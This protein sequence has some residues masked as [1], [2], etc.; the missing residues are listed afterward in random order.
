MRHKSGHQKTPLYVSL[1]LSILLLG[2]G[3]ESAEPDGATVPNNGDEFDTKTG[4]G[5][6][7]GA[8]KPQE[9]AGT[10][11]IGAILRI[12]LRHIKFNDQDPAVHYLQ[13]Y[14]SKMDEALLY[15]IDAA[16]GAREIMEGEDLTREMVISSTDGYEYTGQ[17]DP[18]LEAALQELQ[19]Y[20]KALKGN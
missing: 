2:S 11:T 7:T 12:D 10:K 19:N 4:S 18:Y 16:Y 5:Q 17:E 13:A 20:E 8:G 14:R 6:Q 3:C 1:A 9:E 15:R